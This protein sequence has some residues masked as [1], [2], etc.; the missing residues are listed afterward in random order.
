M[1]PPP[2]FPPGTHPS[3]C[4]QTFRSALWSSCWP[5]TSSS[6]ANCSSSQAIPL[7]RHQ[8]RQSSELGQRCACPRAAAND[9][10]PPAPTRVEPPGVDQLQEQLA[11]LQFA[12]ARLQRQLASS[13]A[14]RH[15]GQHALCDLKREF[16]ALSRELA[17]EIQACR[18]VQALPGTPAALHDASLSV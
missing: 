8:A 3:V 15:K 6:R 18:P 7:P 11:Q 9:L 5:R 13:E 17:G 4:A 14:L 12:H 16:E 1:L 2:P 10:P